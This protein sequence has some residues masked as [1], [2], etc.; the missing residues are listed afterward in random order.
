MKAA[1]FRKG[2]DDIFEVFHTI[3]DSIYFEPWISQDRWNGENA[4]KYK[5]FGKLSC[6]LV[7]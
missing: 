3:F 5:S 6:F 1:S 4:K 2:G 7:E